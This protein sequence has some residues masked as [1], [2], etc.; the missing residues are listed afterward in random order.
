MLHFLDFFVPKS[1]YS[2]SFQEGGEVGLI[3]VL[4]SDVI[5]HITADIDAND[6]GKEKIISVFRLKGSN[7]WTTT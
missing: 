1:V 5:I 2:D 6:H 3:I 4:I 7:T